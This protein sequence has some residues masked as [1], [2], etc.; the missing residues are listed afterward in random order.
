MKR[1]ILV[2]L[3]ILIFSVAVFAENSTL[4]I[5][6][7]VHYPSDLEKTGFDSALTLNI[8]VDKYFTVGAETGFGWM[9]WKDKGESFSGG[10]VTLAETET[11]NLYSL[12]L[13]A[14]ATVRLADMMDNYGFM[15]YVT[16]GAGYSWTWYRSSS[17][18]EDFDGFTWQAMGGVEIK[19]GADSNLALIAEAG[20]RSAAITNP[21]DIE[22]DMS[23]FIGRIG[24]SFPLETSN[25]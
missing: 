9:K 8:G 7:G 19:L 24:I 4:N 16:G 21:D 25:F 5:K 23:G 6:G 3:A 17:F 10:E 20:Y 11:S 22:L 14:V 18:N 1:K 15:P 13:L 2:T 12:P